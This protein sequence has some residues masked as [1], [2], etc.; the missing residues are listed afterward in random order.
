M[1]IIQLIIYNDF[2][3]KYFIIWCV[4]LYIFVIVWFYEQ[5]PYSFYINKKIPMNIPMNASLS[6]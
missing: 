4:V 3:F 1:P 2:E 5:M 6:F